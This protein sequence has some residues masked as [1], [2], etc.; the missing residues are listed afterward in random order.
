MFSMLNK[1]REKPFVKEQQQGKMEDT[2][3]GENWYL[4]LVLGSKLLQKEESFLFFNTA[5]MWF[6]DSIWV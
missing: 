2:R 4:G 6:S 3:S 1:Y 5:L